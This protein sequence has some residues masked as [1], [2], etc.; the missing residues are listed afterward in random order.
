MRKI[1]KTCNLSTVYKVW[2]EDIEDQ[3]LPHEKYTSSNGKY[4][5]DIVMQLYHCQN[6]LCAYTEQMLC[7]TEYLTENNW[8]DGYYSSVIHSKQKGSLD[9]FDPNLKEE[10][11][12][13]WEN[14]FMVDAEVNSAKFKGNKPVDPIL[15][16][17]GEDYDPFHLLEYDLS[18]HEF[19]PNKNLDD[20]TSKRVQ[21]MIN[22]LCLNYCDDSRGELL[23]S[24]LRNIYFQKKNW[25]EIES[26]IRS[27]PT[28]L[29][30]CRN[31]IERN[32]DILQELLFRPSGLDTE[33]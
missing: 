17:D 28:A 14:F 32:P 4:Y 33:I 23:S 5:R 21:Y 26:E 16:P 30:M 6:G 13:L 2:E 8:Q 11:G 20:N 31:Q 22:T 1:N 24:I 18:T 12:W 15:K 7:K 25:N 19:R 27:F 3:G 9:H 10:K 29:K